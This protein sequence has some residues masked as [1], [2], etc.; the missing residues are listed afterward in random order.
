MACSPFVDHG[1]ARGVAVASNGGVIP[2]WV[3]RIVSRGVLPEDGP[4]SDARAV[5]LSHSHLLGRREAVVLAANG[6]DEVHNE[7]EYV[8]NKTKTHS[9]LEDSSRVVLVPVVLY[10]EPNDE[11]QLDEDEGE[12]GPEADTEDAVLS[13]LH[14]EALVLCADEDGGNDIAGKKMPSPV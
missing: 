3:I 12:L 7:T 5:L 4:S 13:E 1:L 11:T 9:P 6:W 14:P 2:C 10:A 8:K